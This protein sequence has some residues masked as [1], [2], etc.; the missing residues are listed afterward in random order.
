MRNPVLRESEILARVLYRDRRVIVLDKPAGV[1]VHAGPGGGQTV[2]DWFPLLGFEFADPPH[3][4]HRLDRDTAGCLVLGR[5]HKSLRKLNALFREGRIGKT[6]WAVVEGAPPEPEGRIALALA[7]RTSRNGGWHM[8]PDPA[9]Q[10]A[11]TSYRVIGAAQ[12]MSFLELTPHTGRTHQIRV[13]CAALGM[14]IVGDSTY[15]SSR[16]EPMQLLA[17]SVEIP[18]QETKPPV[19][20]TAPVPVHMQALARACGMPTA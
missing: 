6:Y 19:V 14:P 16:R 11:A 17:R 4:A 2:E 3:L 1:P 18:L 12:G 15:G 20:V 13:H 8:E 5:T 9:G 7:K 10:A